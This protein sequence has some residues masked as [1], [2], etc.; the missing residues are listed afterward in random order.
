VRR[1]SSRGFI[2][3]S[4]TKGFY[5]KRVIACLLVLAALIVTYN[6]RNR[7]GAPAVN[8]DSALPWLAGQLFIQRLLGAFL[9][10]GTAPLWYLGLDIDR[11][12]LLFIDLFIAWHVWLVLLRFGAFYVG[13]RLGLVPIAWFGATTRLVFPWRFF[14][15]RYLKFARWR[16]QLNYGD[17]PTGS[18][19]SQTAAANRIYTGGDQ[20]PLGRRWRKTF[21]SHQPVAADGSGHVVLLAKTGAGK[22]LWGTSWIKMM[23]RTGSALVVD[24]G[25]DI[26]N[27]IGQALKDDGHP[28]FVI[29]PYGASKFLRCC[30]NPLDEITRA[31]KRH[32]TEAA[33][34]W[35]FVL[36][37]ALIREN[38]P[39][40][41]IFTQGARQ[42]LTGLILF[43]W[44]FEP[45]ER[46]N[47]IRVYELAARGLP[48]RVTDPEK[49]TPLDALGFVMTRAPKMVD[50]G[51]G[52]QITAVIANAAGV[53]K[54][55]SN[56]TGGNP[57]LSTLLT[58]LS[59]VAATLTRSDFACEDLKLTNA[60]VFYVAPVIDIRGVLNGHVR[61]I[62]Y[63]TMY[64]FENIQLRMKT[65]CL[66][67]LDEAP[68][69]KIEYL[70]TAA[71]VA[72][73][74]GYR[75]V[76]V[77]QDLSVLKQGYPTGWRVLLSN[78]LVVLF[79]ATDDIDTLE[80]LHKLC[81]ERTVRV[82]TSGSHWLLNLFGL[83][84][85]KATYQT[86]KQELIS[87]NQLREFLSHARGQCIALIG[88]EPPL[89]LAWEGYLTALALWQYAPSKHY[90]EKLLRH[91]TR[92][93]LSVLWLRVKPPVEISA[94]KE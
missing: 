47:L 51:C 81:G 68:H 22:T 30:W 85:E 46:R 83:S 86:V 93:M 74:A 19:M 23:A 26:V 70:E 1:A 53:L 67:F 18:W 32:G 20:V 4:K 72:R 3:R 21:R 15:R 64:A 8:F 2:K 31:V 60:C 76:I 91:W 39:N 90:R 33:V 36:A 54:H 41:P 10:A 80:Y 66:F 69:L 88:G 14:Y 16:S 6:I 25:A 75:L 40:Q 24:V 71:P 12:F 55:G 11:P 87:L 79:F 49:Q 73:K 38:N 94:A 77:A 50:D 56:R 48:E 65:P 59:W 42:F 9:I 45:P 28:L 37:E 82:R 58:A 13:R 5:M 84:K 17:G 62:S 27:A 61:A 29:D 35:A 7:L 44:L 34:R 43:V 89:R 92:K 57:F 52:G 63:C 78:A